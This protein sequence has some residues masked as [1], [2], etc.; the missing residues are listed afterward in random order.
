MVICLERGADLHMAQLMPLP[1]TG[2]CF[3]KIQ[4]GFTFLVPAHPG[5][6]GKR[7]VKRVYVVSYV[8]PSGV[9]ASLREDVVV[10]VRER[11]AEVAHAARR[12]LPQV[13]VGVAQHRVSRVPSEA[14]RRRRRGRE[15]D[16]GEAREV[17]RDV[18]AV[19]E[20]GE[21]LADGLELGRRERA[22]DEHGDV[23]RRVERVVH[24]RCTC[25]V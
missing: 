4:I 14:E 2:S 3:S 5:S 22:V 24:V 10:G 9:D 11:G 7:A 16:G 23:E 25:T 19:L 15:L 8:Y 18:E 21:E 17:R 6:P 12:L 1:L 20:G 13:R